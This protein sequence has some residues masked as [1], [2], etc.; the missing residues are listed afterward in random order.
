MKK[1][2]LVILVGL[3]VALSPEAHAIEVGGMYYGINSDSTTVF[4]T[5]GP[6]KYRGDITIPNTIAYEGKTYTVSSI[7]H[8]AFS[9]CNDLTSVAM[10][11]TINFIGSDAFSS[12]LSLR[13]VT[14][15]QSVKTIANFAFYGCSAL[16]EI[17]IPDNV[18][19]IGESICSY[20]NSLTS[21][22]IGDGATGIGYRAFMGC[23]KLKEITIGKNVAFIGD[24]A[25]YN[26]TGLTKV[27]IKDLA[28]W[29]LI[30]FDGSAA[31]N[32][33]CYAHHLF[34]DGQEIKDLV[35]SETISE[36]R[37]FTFTGGSGFTSID[38]G[39]VTSIGWASFASCTGL[40]TI[41]FG[42]S[43]TTI[44]NSAFGGC[45][46][47]KSL[48]FPRS[49]TEIGYYAFQEC[50][51]LT[52]VRCLSI[53]PPE[54]HEGTTFSEIC[55]RKATLTVPKNSISNYTVGWCEWRAF[56]HIVEWQFHECDVNCDGEVNIA[57]INMIIE[58]IL[59]GRSGDIYD[60]NYDSEINIADVN[61]VIHMILTI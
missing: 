24:E 29:C 51:S 4:V 23:R 38:L 7:G 11:N 60:V 34:L 14:I 19:T 46:G 6:N 44:G 52:S 10:G 8:S 55:Y 2:L 13:A 20:C 32:P 37:N 16:T 25:F 21:A 31:A 59:S 48:T 36:I 49:L 41:N 17:I 54:L 9:G 42:K 22:T 61:E 35:I 15:G 40:E 45:T 47:L 53:I 3:L 50:D 56:R 12:C 39:H 58:A 26:C 28:A 1:I 33:L 43:L 30:D 5:Y 57:D 18:T 27:N